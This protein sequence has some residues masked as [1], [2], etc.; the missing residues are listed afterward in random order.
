MVAG[1]GIVQRGRGET[2]L[3][4]SVMEGWYGGPCEIVF[5]GLLWRAAFVARERNERCVGRI[6]AEL[7]IWIM[8]GG[9][10]CRYVWCCITAWG[11]IPLGFM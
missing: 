1:R 3:W 8:G 5:V 11:L 6:V 4:F 10:T 7:L 2:L 9:D